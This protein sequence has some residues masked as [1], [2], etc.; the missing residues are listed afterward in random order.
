MLALIDLF[1]LFFLTFDMEKSVDTTRKSTLK[2][3][4]LLSLKVIRLKRAG[5]G[6]GARIF[7][8]K[9]TS[10]CKWPITLSLELHFS[11]NLPAQ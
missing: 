11:G 8:T 10:S 4:N 5:G 2:L 9:M 7:S 1:M 6:R 3:D